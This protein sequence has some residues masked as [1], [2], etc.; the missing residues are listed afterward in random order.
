[1]I[2]ISKKLSKGFAFVRLDL[3]VLNN[4][5]IKFGEMTFTPASGTLNFSP[6]NQNRI[7]GDMINLPPKS[8]FPKKN[9]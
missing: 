2:D 6:L 3:Y 9:S 5:D 1:M 7:F 8:P 4:G